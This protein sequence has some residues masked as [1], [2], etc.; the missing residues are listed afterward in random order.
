[1]TL[2]EMLAIQQGQMAAAAAAK[3]HRRRR[4]AFLLLLSESPSSN[5][6]HTGYISSQKLETSK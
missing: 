4:I 1:V 3:N 2:G 5:E 6:L